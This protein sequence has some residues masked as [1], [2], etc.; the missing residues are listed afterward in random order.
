MRKVDDVTRPVHA[1][2]PPSGASGLLAGGKL[3]QLLRS[4]ERFAE[5][6]KLE[7]ENSA[8]TLGKSMP[9]ACVIRTQVGSDVA[10]SGRQVAS[11]GS[12]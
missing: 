2:K 5:N 9:N 10:V 12:C 7:V 4:T 11:P 3:G 8:Q 1:C 6:V